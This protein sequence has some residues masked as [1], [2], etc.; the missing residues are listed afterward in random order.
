MAR[1]SWLAFCSLV[2]DEQQLRLRHKVAVSTHPTLLVLCGILLVE[3]SAYGGI[4]T[5]IDT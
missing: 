5:N 4:Y 3:F 1:G 2:L